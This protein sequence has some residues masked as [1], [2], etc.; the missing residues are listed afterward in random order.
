MTTNQQKHYIPTA[1]NIMTVWRNKRHLQHN[2]LQILLF[3]YCFLRNGVTSTRPYDVIQLKAAHTHSSH[4]TTQQS[5]GEIKLDNPLGKHLWQPT[6]WINTLL[7]HSVWML[8]Q[9]WNRSCTALANWCRHGAVKDVSSHRRRKTPLVKVVFP[10]GKMYRGSS[11]NTLSCN[12]I[13]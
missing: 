1:I 12:L 10:F 9:L 11:I 2:T 5:N 13:P 4:S 7:I 3:L 8:T 6:G